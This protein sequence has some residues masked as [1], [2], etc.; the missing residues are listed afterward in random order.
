[1]AT[2]AALL[3]GATACGND[4]PKAEARAACVNAAGPLIECDPV[5]LAGAED[6]CWRLVQCGAIP[7]ANPESE[8]DGGFD[9][10]ACVDFIER[11]PDQRFELALACIEA[12]ACDELKAGG[13]QARPS[14]PPACLDQGQL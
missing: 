1:M 8:P 13:G 2:L 6:A 9:W 11:L 4:A 7:V 12:S 3:S 10:S 14:E 5:P